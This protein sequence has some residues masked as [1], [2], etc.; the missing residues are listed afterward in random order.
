MVDQRRDY[1]PGALEPQAR[2]DEDLLGAGGDE[3]VDEVLRQG[4]VDR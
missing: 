4:E 2:T 1:L 3:A